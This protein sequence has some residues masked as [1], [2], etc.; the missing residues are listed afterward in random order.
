MKKWML[1]TA[2][3]ITLLIAFVLW[4]PGI[5][6]AEAGDY[7]CELG[8]LFALSGFILVLYQ[9]ML[10]SKLPL[11]E[12][13]IGQDK[14]N[15]MHRVEGIFG[16]SLMTAH[17]VFHF[18]SD[19]INL[20]KLDLKFPMIL[21]LIALI[22]VVLTSGSALLF[23]KL[24]LKYAN[25]KGLHWI[26]FTILPIVFVHSMLLGTDINAV[27]ALKTYW[28]LLGGLY[29]LLVAAII[30]NRAAQRA[31]TFQV[32]RV[33]KETHNIWN[34][35]L[36]GDAVEYKPGQFALLT[37]IRKG[38]K[39]EPHPFTVASSPTSWGLS[40]SVKAVGDFTSVI[41]DAH[42]GDKAVIGVPYG[43]FSFTLHDALNLVFIAGGIGI[44]PF[45][46]MLRYMVDRKMER[47]VLLLWGNKTEADIA[48]KGELEE[49]YRVLPSLKVVH[50]ISNQ[51]DYPGLKG[52]IDTQLLQKYLPDYDNAQFFVC[53]PPSMM[54][55]IIKQLKGLGVPKKRIHFEKFILP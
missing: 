53:G 28:F 45:M 18:S 25:W 37:L 29:L 16:L 40:F 54:E 21:G 34:V 48:F 26:N 44:T 11:V 46:S 9:V 36:K 20:G 2:L 43:T 52:H 3:G 47:N 19:L 1:Y 17:P 22:L 23:K 50:V 10:S 49:M 33:E 42:P 12:R 30:K 24:K 35:H 13:A 14:L 51:P 5:L 32:E 6:A 41:K 27:P 39:P 8:R 55:S 31:H 38:E 15:G 4:F 7:P